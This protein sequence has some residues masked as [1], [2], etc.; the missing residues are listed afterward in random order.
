MAES[1]KQRL[2]K[3]LDRSLGER[4]FTR[5]SDRFYGDRYDR[6]IHGGRQSIALASHKRN[7]ALILDPAFAGIRLD[8]VE[9]DVFR[10][11]EK[12]ELVGKEDSLRRNTIGVRLDKHELL[13]VI[14]GR[15]AIV[16]E[17]DCTRVGDK[18]ARQMLGMADRFWKSVPTPQAILAKL[19]NVP[20]DAHKY[21]GTDV[22]AAMRAIVLTRMLHGNG[23]AR[24]FADEVLSRLSGTPALELAR[25]RARAFETWA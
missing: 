7:R 13:T 11:E 21:A 4:G 2:L 5:Q 17:D 9:D 14:T 18:Y 16:T 8:E 22:F 24:R 23:E 25:W 15:Y 10:F 3:E 6:A 12:S 20:G 19:T 1:L